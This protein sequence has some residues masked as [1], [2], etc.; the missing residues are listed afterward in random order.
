MTWY[1]K[2][3][4]NTAQRTKGTDGTY[5]MSKFEAGYG[6]ELDLRLKAKDIADYETQVSFPL[7]VNGYKVATYIADFVVYHNNGAKEIVE[8][9][10]YATD[11]FKLKWKLTEA[12]YGEEY[13]LTLIHMGKGNLR[14]PKKVIEF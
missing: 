2:N 10:G 6:N 5:Y 3:Y 9:K 14:P 11:I 1:K 4:Y 7:I 13:T 12:L 8:T